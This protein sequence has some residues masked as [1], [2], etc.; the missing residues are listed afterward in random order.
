MSGART[1]RGSLAS[2]RLGLRAALTAAKGPRPAPRIVGGAL[3]GAWVGLAAALTA[4]PWGSLGEWRMVG[5][6][7]SH[8]EW[9]FGVPFLGGLVVSGVTW[10]PNRVARAVMAAISGAVLL[11]VFDLG[12]ATLGATTALFAAGLA[13]VGW[14]LDAAVSPPWFARGRARGLLVVLSVVTTAGALLVAER[15]PEPLPADAGPWW[16]VAVLS[17][18]TGVVCLVHAAQDALAVRL[19]GRIGRAGFEPRDAPEGA[20]D[21]IATPGF[22]G[23]IY[24]GR[25]PVPQGRGAYRAG[26]AS[27]PIVQ[28]LSPPGAARRWLAASALGLAVTG[29]VLLALAA[30]TSAALADREEAGRRFLADP[31]AVSVE[32]APPRPAPPA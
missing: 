16:L 6:S 1:T 32:P 17:T 29:A 14:T 2:L 19:I 22:R 10:I 15:L 11:A 21:A 20:I 12:G 18:S 13:G 7:A 31:A 25:L 27:L 8:A 5:G 9:I 30:H 24:L 28:L 3:A 23:R 26:E 4:A